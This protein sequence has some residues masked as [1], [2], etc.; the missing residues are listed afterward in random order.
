MTQKG[1]LYSV[2]YRGAYEILLHISVEKLAKLN[3]GDWNTLTWL[4]IKYR[5]VRTKIYGECPFIELEKLE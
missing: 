2:T 1:D 3:R 5:S 4:R